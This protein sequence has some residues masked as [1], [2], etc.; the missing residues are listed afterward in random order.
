[1]RRAKKDEQYQ[2]YEFKKTTRYS[3]KNEKSW[4]EAHPALGEPGWEHL[5]TN[6]RDAY[7]EALTNKDA[8]YRFKRFY[9][10]KVHQWMKTFG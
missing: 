9:V 6:Y 8:E 3:W 7:K 5:L 2:V 1:M 4:Y 10:L